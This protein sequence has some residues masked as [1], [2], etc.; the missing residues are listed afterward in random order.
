MLGY[1]GVFVGVKS[2]FKF[3]AKA[4]ISFESPEEENYVKRYIAHHGKESHKPELL[5]LPFTGPA[6]I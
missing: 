4:P 2:Y 6:T 3:K 1:I 5:R